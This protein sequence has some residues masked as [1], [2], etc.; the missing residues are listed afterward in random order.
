ML[1]ENNVSQLWTISDVAQYLNVK[2]S[3][4]RQWIY[5]RRVRYF[6]VGRLVRFAP[7]TIKED[8]QRGIIGQAVS[9]PEIRKSDKACP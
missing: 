4:V 3:T 7:G 5:E 8:A 2:E 9:S 6:K 1:E